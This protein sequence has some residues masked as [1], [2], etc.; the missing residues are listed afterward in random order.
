MDRW[1]PEDGGDKFTGK[2]FLGFGESSDHYGMWAETYVDLYVL[3]LFLQLPEVLSS[4]H[5]NSSLLC[6]IIPAGANRSPPPLIS[7]L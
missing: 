1:V 5:A 2:V 6:I 7:V 3:A 4:Q